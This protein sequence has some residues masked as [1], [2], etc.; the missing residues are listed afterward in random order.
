MT[1]EALL[2]DVVMVVAVMIMPGTLLLL[3]LQQQHPRGVGDGV[4]IHQWLR[5]D[6]LRVGRV[7]DV[8]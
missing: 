5:E 2:P 8:A 7:G 3:L 1:R 4:D 6:V